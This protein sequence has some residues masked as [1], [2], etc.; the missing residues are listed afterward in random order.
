MNLIHFFI[1]IS[2]ALNVAKCVL[3]SFSYVQTLEVQRFWNKTKNV[4]KSLMNN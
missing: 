1:L 2:K 3:V 4:L